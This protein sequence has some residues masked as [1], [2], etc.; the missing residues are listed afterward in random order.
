MAGKSGASATAATQTQ[1]RPVIN[2]S[3]PGVQSLVVKTGKG[4]SQKSTL[5]PLNTQESFKSKRE[6]TS[7]SNVIG[8]KKQDAPQ[9]NRKVILYIERKKFILQLRR[10]QRNESHLETKKIKL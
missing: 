6:A 9:Q 4:N 7:G 10:H 3:N 2:K 8:T 5:P 1:V